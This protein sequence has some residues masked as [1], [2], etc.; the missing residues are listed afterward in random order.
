M[1]EIKSEGGHQIKKCRSLQSRNHTS[2]GIRTFHATNTKDAEFRIHLNQVVQEN[3]G[4]SDFSVED[5]AKAM[6]V[7]RINCIVN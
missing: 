1:A 4:N 7:S 2:D 5:F 3:I 6:F